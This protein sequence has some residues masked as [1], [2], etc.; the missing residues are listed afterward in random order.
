MAYLTCN[1]SFIN[2][3]YG[4]RMGLTYRQAK[5]KLSLKDKIRLKLM[6]YLGRSRNS[7]KDKLQDKSL[8]AAG[9][10]IKNPGKIAAGTALAIGTGYGANKLRKKENR[11]LLVN[12]VNSLLN[13]KPNPSEKKK[14][15]D[16]NPHSA[17]DSKTGTKYTHNPETGKWTAEEPVK[18]VAQI[19][20]EGIKT[21]KN[22]ETGQKILGAAT[23]A[24]NK[25]QAT[26]EN[27]KNSETGKKVMDT[28]TQA[29][30]QAQAT[31][32]KM[33]NSETGQKILG[34]ATQ[35]KNK[36]QATAEKMKNS[37]TGQKIIGAMRSMFGG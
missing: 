30:N 18:S 7:L 27:F 1:E 26:A 20:D 17:I 35:A 2:P 5:G 37:E 6:K 9:Y 24:K 15:T 31:A 11:E 22:S 3:T 13:N 32:E 29:K 34:A 14:E 28:A 33:K 36:A 8:Q 19:A 16:S 21:A 12:K 23:Q 4:E 25:A 10:A